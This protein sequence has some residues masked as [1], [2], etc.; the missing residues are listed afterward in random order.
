M[1]N[2]KYIFALIMTMGLGKATFAQEQVSTSSP[3]MHYYLLIT[4]AIIL[5]VIIL[6]LNSAI[7]GIVSN[8][9]IISQI[10]EKKG[11]GIVAALLFA[12]LSNNAIAQEATGGMVVVEPNYGLVFWMFLLVNLI[13]IIIV[14]VQLSVINGLTKALR[15]ESASVA[16]VDVV[17][18]PSAIGKFWESLTDAVPLEREEEVMTDH[19]YDGIK[20]LDNK[21]PP[22]WVWM[23]NLS[24]LFAVVYFSYYQ[25]F[26]ASDLPISIQEYNAEMAQAEE[27]IAAYKAKYGSGVDENT[28]VLIV[29]EGRLANGKKI[30]TANCVS[31]H[32]DDGGGGIGPNFTDEYWLH[33]G[34]INDLFKT[35]KYGVITKGMIPWKDQLKPEEIEDVASYILT[36]FP[37]TTPANPK[38]P[39]GEIYTP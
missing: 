5:L 21:L 1:K 11:M 19:E 13:F 2:L 23:F 17:E 30:Y 18:E 10:K 4:S 29:D 6:V 33:G 31:C 15:E 12:G 20:E 27:E 39:Q 38:E 32:M 3:E 34:S 26:N 14:I 24:I 16:D 9:S 22:W 36:A 28:A 8:K 25:V 37:G 35:I 7:K